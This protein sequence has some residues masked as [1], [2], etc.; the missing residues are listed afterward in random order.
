VCP[1]VTVAG[2]GKWPY[3]CTE[4]HLIV[5]PA[6]PSSRQ[7]RLCTY[8]KTGHDGVPSASPPSACA[9]QVSQSIEQFIVLR[10][11]LGPSES[12]FELPEFRNLQP[13][14]HATKILRL[15]SCW[16]SGRRT[17]NIQDGMA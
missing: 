10:R 5:P 16:A 2:S 13:D 15:G 4:N 7:R 6:R 14:P 17:V 8:K 9:M 3:V 11:Q 12:I 1:S